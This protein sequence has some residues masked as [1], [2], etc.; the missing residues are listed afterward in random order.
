IHYKGRSPAHRPSFANKRDNTRA[1]YAQE[2]VKLTQSAKDAA[3][4]RNL[5][6]V[7]KHRF[8][9]TDV[10]PA[11]VAALYLLIFSAHLGIGANGQRVGGPGGKTDPAP[12]EF[13]DRM[14]QSHTTALPT[15]NSSALNSSALNSSALNSSVLNSSALN[16]SAL[17]SLA[18]NS[19]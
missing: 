16:S 11:L 7:A 8:L 1:L 15:G 10:D 5:D 19:S 2:Q 3:L 6:R 13:R 18:L 4:L 12:R 9:G 17:N 14:N